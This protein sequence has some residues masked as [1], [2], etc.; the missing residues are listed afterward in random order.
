M[1]CPRSA[2]AR[3]LENLI[4]AVRQYGVPLL[5]SS[6]GGDGTDDHVN[7]FLRIIDEIMRNPGMVLFTLANPS[8]RKKLEKSCRALAIP[9]VAPLDRWGAQVAQIGNEERQNLSSDQVEPAYEA[10]RQR[11]ARRFST[12]SESVQ[13]T[14]EVRS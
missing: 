2:Y 9:F 10:W 1:T 3:D 8:L 13:E 7:E 12:W 6:A 4:L 11:L 14:K 5:I